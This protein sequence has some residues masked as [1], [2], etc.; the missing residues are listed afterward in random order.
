[1]KLNKDQEK[2]A[3]GFLRFLHSDQPAMIITGGA[4]YGKTHLMRH[5]SNTV[6]PKYKKECRDKGVSPRF[7]DTL[8][9]AATNR[10]A[11][12]LTDMVGEPATT[13]HS[14]LGLRL[15]VNYRTGVTFLEE[16]KKSHHDRGYACRDSV[17]IIDEA[18][19]LSEEV[20]KKLFSLTS[21]CKFLFVGDEYQLAPPEDEVSVL[22]K[23]NLP[24]FRLTQPM[25]NADTNELVL[26]SDQLRKTVKTQEFNPITP[27]KSVI[28][29]VEFRTWNKLIEEHFQKPTAN[30]RILTYTNNQAIQYIERIKTIRGAKRP[31]NYPEH[32]PLQGDH[33]VVNNAIATSKDLINTD[34]EVK[35][36]KVNRKG[37]TTD[38]S[39]KFN[40][41]IPVEVHEVELITPGNE[42]FRTLIPKDKEDF[43]RLQR[44]AKR[45][46]DW[47]LY[48]SLRENIA[49][50]RSIDASTVHKS[51]GGTFDEVFVDLR[52]IGTCKDK[53]TLAR[54]MYVAATR[55]RKRVVFY[56]FMKHEGGVDGDFTLE[57]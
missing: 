53:D 52:D 2:A 9:T 50:L 31:P 37:F 19:M 29:W 36:L 43:L 12:V 28:E 5:L 20:Y 25:R 34:Q 13:I 47:L 14:L 32:L 8:F 10:A 23:K 40:G 57:L 24:T 46:K 48:Y 26:L 54:L 45:Q 38:V 22:S 41:D 7:T 27:V 56:G 3:E 17:I 6:F 39:S 55:A 18:Y 44:D 15:F 51:Q 33:L 49:D 4:G 16:T 11:T 42:V 1:M 30:K 35:V 21:N